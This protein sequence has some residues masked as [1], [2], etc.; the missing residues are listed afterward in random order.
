VLDPAASGTA[1]CIWSLAVI[2]LAP[3]PF[4]ARSPAMPPRI[5]E[6]ARGEAGSGSRTCI[7]GL[8]SRRP[9]RWTI[10][11]PLPR[12]YAAES[13]DGLTA[14]LWE[15]MAFIFDIPHRPGSSP[16]VGSK[17]PA[18]VLPLLERLEVGDERIEVV[19]GDDPAPVGHARYRR[20]ADNAARADH[21][22]DLL[23]SVELLAELLP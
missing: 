21:F 13:G 10:P 23:V 20:L 3:R 22:G 16:G 2:L 11:A 4:S 5:Q 1:A 14:R 17:S 12:L 15:P 8:V 9:N 19:V 7:C 6:R 18:S